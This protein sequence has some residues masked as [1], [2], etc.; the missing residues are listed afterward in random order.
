MNEL[1]HIPDDRRA[2]AYSPKQFWLGFRR[3]MGAWAI[4]TLL[5]GGGSAV[6]SVL[7]VA[8]SQQFEFD[9]ELESLR[10]DGLVWALRLGTVTCSQFITTQIGINA[11][12]PDFEH[13]QRQV[14]DGTLQRT[15]QG[16]YL[17]YLR[18]EHWPKVLTLVRSVG[19]NGQTSSVVRQNGWKLIVHYLGFSLLVG[20]LTAF[21]VEFFKHKRNPF[22]L[23]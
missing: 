16:T 13:E 17:A 4:A 10:K 20:F 7:Y 6:M 3:F 18:G 15:Y 12:N 8:S 11:E 5:L 14:Q 1:L 21:S 22:L 23:P 9:S 19:E 2:S